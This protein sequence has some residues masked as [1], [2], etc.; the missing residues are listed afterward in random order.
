MTAAFVVVH[1]GRN[2]A[3]RYMDGVTKDTQLESWSMGKSLTA[4]LFALLVKDGVYS[5]DQP[6]P[7]PLWQSPGDERQ[8][9][10]VR[11]L[12]NMSSGLRFVG[13]QDPA[14]S[15]RQAYPDHYYIYTGAIDAF[16]YSMTRPLEFEPGTE[17]RYR[18]SDPLTIGYLVKRE[19]ERRGENY[20][21]W[22]QKALFDRL[23]IRRQV[24]EPDPYGNF[25]MTGYDY[26]T[27]RN[28]AR[29]GL[30]YLQDGM[31]MGERLLPEGWAEFVS[32]SAPG[33][34]RPEYGGLF[35]LNRVGTWT[36]P[37]DTYLAAGAGGQNT[38]I[39]PSL[40]LVIV[41]MGH[42]RGTAGGASR[43]ANNRAF[44]LIKEALGVRE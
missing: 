21:T 4:T 11:D 38:Y 20:L 39:V 2:I 26:G 35:W 41:R 32:T 31:W 27:A 16:T 33:W 13:N 5:L 42:F 19:V 10:R 40:D 24:L 6:A 25:L 34:R 14:G 8:K 3:E 43:R 36:L 28:W 22:P 37:E 7:V 44:T 29:I 9:I 1:K 23:G 30:L 17:G 18:N 12:M 15:R